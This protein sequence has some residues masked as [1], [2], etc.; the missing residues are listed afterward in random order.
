[1]S[2]EDGYFRRRKTQYGQL[3]GLL[4]TTRS[5]RRLCGF[6]L[7][8]QVWVASPG[9]LFRPAALMLWDLPERAIITYALVYHQQQIKLSPAPVPARFFATGHSFEEVVRRF[10]QEGIEAPFWCDFD[11]MEIGT[12]FRISVLDGHGLPALGLQALLL[13]QAAL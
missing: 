12:T 6:E 1:M 3:G 9:A 13:G 2:A 10:E 11:T 8:G 5:V 7:D 4:N